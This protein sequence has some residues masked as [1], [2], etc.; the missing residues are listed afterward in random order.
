MKY[1]IA[2][3]ALL[4]LLALLA[5]LSAH[6]LAQTS[7]QVSH[8]LVS[9]LAAARRQDERTAQRLACEAATIWQA[10][11]RAVACLLHHA[12]VDEIARRLARLPHS[13]G[14]EFC[15]LCAELLWQLGHLRDM[16][17]P[18]LHSLL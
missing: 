13:S 12:E 3:L 16:E 10:H 8:P 5:G 1:L 7:A 2:G 17:L 14:D 18:L 6:Y 9:A 4:L 11:S 15:G